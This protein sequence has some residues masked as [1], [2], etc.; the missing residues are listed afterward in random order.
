MP[1]DL[2]I[3][4]T[5]PA[6][7]MTAERAAAKGLKTLVL[8]KRKAVT[9]SLMGELVTDNALK[10]LRVKPT[11]EY[12]GNRYTAVIGESLDTG[13]NIVV[14]EGLLGNSYLL[15]EDKCQELMRDRAEA[16]G[17]EFRYGTRVQSVVKEA[18]QVIGVKHSD[19]EERSQLTVGADGAF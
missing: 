15:D 14:G 2:I 19:G 7:L 3:A 11:S 4:G 5:G 18:D 10:L 9:D 16:D 6:G 13:A 17:A 12:V 1:H 8:E